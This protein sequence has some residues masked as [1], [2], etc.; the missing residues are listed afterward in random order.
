MEE[1]LQV[2]PGTRPRTVID[3]EGRAREI[4][5]GWTL[6]P[7]GDAGL[8]RKLKS[9]GPTWTVKEK[10][11]RRSF[12][13]GVWACGKQIAEAK[14]LVAAHRADPIYEKKLN[15]S[16][17]YRHRKQEK[18]VENFEQAIL[19]FLRFESVHGE[20]AHAIAEAVTSHAT[21]VGSGTVARTERIPIEQR[22]ES[23]VI[24]WMRHQTTAYD[25]MSIARKKGERRAVR[26]ELAQ[27]SRSLL[28]RYRRGVIPSSSCPLAKWFEGQA[29]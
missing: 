11:G 26:R 6:L 28:D 8:T 23:A 12:S 9:L 25:N 10:K 27:K 19:Q 14:R 22:A 13:K 21:P 1:T 17:E 16:R 29:T 5:K 20:M 3:G 4:P 18:Y 15:A 2:K 7:P 24:A